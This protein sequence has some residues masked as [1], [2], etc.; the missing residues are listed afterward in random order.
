MTSERLFNN[1]IPPH[2]KIYP[3]NKFLATPL[4]SNLS[5]LS[6]IEWCPRNFVMI[7]LTV[8]TNRQTNTQT[9]TTESNTTLAV[10][11]VNIWRLGYTE[12]ELA[13]A[14]QCSVNLNVGSV[15][16]DLK[17]HDFVSG[18]NITTTHVITLSYIAVTDIN[19]SILLVEIHYRVS[20]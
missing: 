1:F 16:S 7:F 17:I 13:L 19:K 6:T 4:F 18:A 15:N 20:Q 11:V 12:N 14:T 8:Q 5:A 10:R 2:K 9:D 3:Q